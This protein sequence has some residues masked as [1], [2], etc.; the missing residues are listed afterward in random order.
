MGMVSNDEIE[1]VATGIV[2]ACVKVHRELGPGLLE[3][4]YQVCLAYELRTRGLEE[5]ER[6]ADQGWNKTEGQQ[7]MTTPPLI[8]LRSLR[9]RGERIGDINDRT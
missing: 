6:A 2:D 7:A 9:L 1:R 3:S 8:S 4:T 5:L